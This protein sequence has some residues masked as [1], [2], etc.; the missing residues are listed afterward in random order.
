M[1]DEREVDAEPIAVTYALYGDAPWEELTVVDAEGPLLQRDLMAE[2]GVAPDLVRIRWGGAR[3][4][5]R[6]RWASWTG[7][8]EVSGAELLG[9]EPWAFLHKEQTIAVDGSRL[10]WDARTFGD[11]VGAVLRLGPGDD[12]EIAIE[13]TVVEDG[14][15][16]TF[17]VRRADLAAGPCRRD[18][19]GA[20]LHVT[21]EPVAPSEE[22]PLTV[23]GE[24]TVTPPPGDS[25]VYL[26]ARQADGHEVWT[27]PLFF[28]RREP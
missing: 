19:G 18:L 12:A 9:A 14:R 3:H 17:V 1:G 10:S 5:D 28:S 11:D 15:T 13:A 23:T 4:R 24:L 26:H 21:V 2:R 7:S 20:G 27:S 8:A 16:E 25:A 6:Y 22:L